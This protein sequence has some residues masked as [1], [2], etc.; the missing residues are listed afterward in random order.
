MADINFS[1]AS[2]IAPKSAVS[3]R[4]VYTGGTTAAG[5][6]LLKQ[7]NLS[8]NSTGTITSTTKKVRINNA[9]DIVTPPTVQSVTAN[10]PLI[11]IDLSLGS[12]IHLLQT[13]S[14]IIQFT[15]LPTEGIRF[16]EI[17]RTHAAN[18]TTYTMEFSTS[19]GWYH[20]GG[21]YVV[22]TQTS[23]AIDKIAGWVDSTGDIVTIMPVLNYKSGALEYSRD[24]M[25]FL[26]HMAN[27]NRDY[28]KRPDKINPMVSGVTD[29]M[30]IT[31]MD[32]KTLNACALTTDGAE[33]F[34]LAELYNV[35][36]K[37]KNTRH[38]FKDSSPTLTVDLINEDFISLTHNSDIDAVDLI[39]SDPDYAT[40]CLIWRIKDA[41]STPRSIYF[42]PAIFK[43]E[44]YPL[45]TQTA[46][47][48]DLIYIESLG[49]VNKVM[50]RNYF[51]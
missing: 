30:T 16:F 51:A 24:S 44:V 36:A 43:F 9:I 39:Q 42:D 2:A 25:S 38:V 37:M 48:V 13:A 50:V 6:V 17:I 27:T 3:G 26:Y 45:L 41:T 49:G 28:N 18:N 8:I 10:A 34:E 4:I 29:G 46:S 21:N 12:T 14:T 5:Q 23:N 19:H 20:E 11:A 35:M 32:D 31:T 1:T 33:T 22:W 47:G 40:S 7:H 15:N